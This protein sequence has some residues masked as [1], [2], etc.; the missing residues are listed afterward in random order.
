[1]KKFFSVIILLSIL[2]GQN[3]SAQ[4]P[5]EAENPGMSFLKLGMGARPCGMGEAFTSVSGDIASLYWNPAGLSRIEGFEAT[6]LHNR[7]FQDIATEYLGTVLRLKRNVFGL[8]LT[9]NK[10]P[11]IER[12]VSASTEPL[13][14]FDAHQFSGGITWARSFSPLIDFGLSAKWVYEKIDLSSASGWGL[15]GGGIFHI[16]KNLN[17]GACVLNLG[18]KIKFDEQKFSLPTY[19]KL[20]ASYLKEEK[21]LNGDFFVTLD[22]AKL[23][24]ADWKIHTGIEYT[25]QNSFSLRGGYQFGYDEKSYSLG[26][27]LKINRQD[28]SQR[29]GID[30]AFVPFGSDLGNTHRISFSIK[31]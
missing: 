13:G 15:D 22:L 2:S 28:A 27:G 24:D 12:R 9:L 3:L 5:R 8:S 25:Y 1:M 20:G 31:L 30:Y 29:Y 21:R 18:P 10:V 16:R 23:K 14:T 11:D 6:F 19:Y 26:F 7:W 4:I 17:I